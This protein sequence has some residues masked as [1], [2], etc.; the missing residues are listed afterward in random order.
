MGPILPSN[1]DIQLPMQSGL[2]T[3]LELS[4]SRKSREMI[5]KE[6]GKLNYSN[7]EFERASWK[8]V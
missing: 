5:P 8:K 3:N 2:H 4:V 1:T 7:S 6:R